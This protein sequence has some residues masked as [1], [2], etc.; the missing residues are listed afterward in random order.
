MNRT[1]R[2]E[3]IEQ[4]LLN[5]PEGL[6]AVEISALCNVDRRT[7]YRDLEYMQEKGL[8]LWQHQGKFGIERESYMAQL[9]INANEAATLIWAVRF[10]SHH[11]K[12]RNPHLVTLLK[13]IVA[14]LPPELSEPIAPFSNPT[15][16]SGA[17]HP[18]IKVIEI[19]TT[20]WI[21]NVSAEIWYT[22]R[23][24]STAKSRIFSPYVLDIDVRGQLY[25]VGYDESSEEIRPFKLNRISRARLLH[26][27]TFTIPD[28]FDARPYM[29]AAAQSHEADTETIVLRLH[30]RLIKQIQLQ[31]WYTH[32]HLEYLENGHCLFIADVADG[33]EMETW[34]QASGKYIEIIAPQKLRKRLSAP[35]G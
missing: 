5:H 8:P 9:R 3:V 27:K 34:V 4:I 10:L 18:Q 25:A 29:L 1:H 11:L 20:A 12:P 16:L 23:G 15:P 21:E 22:S 2:L 19:L 13:R 26:E 6:R 28:Q 31:K 33:R 14:A 32:S 35:T 24:T 7:I 17:P 30:P